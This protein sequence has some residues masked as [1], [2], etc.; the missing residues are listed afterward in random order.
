VIV[1]VHELSWIYEGGKHF[2]D[3]VKIIISSDSNP[4]FDSEFVKLFVNEFWDDYFKKLLGKM[5]LP[6]VAHV[7]LVF[8]HLSLAL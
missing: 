8:A 2:P 4:V 1:R 6:F 3:L 7:I 5:F